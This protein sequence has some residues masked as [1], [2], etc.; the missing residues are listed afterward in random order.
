MNGQIIGK[1]KFSADAKN[2]T[3][4]GRFSVNHQKLG[5][6]LDVSIDD[7]LVFNNGKQIRL[8]WSDAASIKEARCVILLWSQ[9][10]PK[11]NNI[12]CHSFSWVSTIFF[13]YPVWS[14]D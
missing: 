3:Y 5:V 1:K 10:S 12:Y 7:I 4:F 2:N 11:E 8:K 9:W 6:K 14:S 13:S